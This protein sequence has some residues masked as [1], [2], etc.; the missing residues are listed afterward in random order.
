D[1]RRVAMSDLTGQTRYAYNE[2]GELTGVR[3]GDGSLITYTYDD[4]GNITKLVYPDGSEVAYSY[5]ELDRLTKVTDRDGKVTT[6]AYDKAG[7]MTKIERGDG[8]TSALTYDAAHRVTEIVHRDKKGKLIS[9][10]AYEYDDGNYIDKE[11]ITQDGETLVQT[12]T[13][14]SLGQI[15][16]MTVSS[17]DGKEL[18]QFSYTYDHAGNKLTSTETVDGK[19]SKTEFSYDAENRLL[20]MKSGDKTITYTYDKNG[21]RTS[22]GAGDAKLDYIYDTENRL[23]AVKDKEGLLFAALYDG[24]DNRVFTASRTQA[25]NTYQL[26]KRK[27]ADKKRKSPYTAPDGEANSLFWYGFTQNVVQFFSNFTTSEGYDWIETFDTVS[28]AYHQ[29]VAKDRAT[30]EGLVVNPPS[31]DNLPGEDEVLYRSQV[32]DVLIPYT[33]KEDTYNYYE[34]RNYV[35]DVN[36]QHTQVLQT[37]DDQLQKRETYVYGNGRATYTNES[38]GDSY[39]YLTS[40]S[41]SVTGLTQNGQAVAS[42]SYTLYGATKQTTDTT[43]NPFAYNGEARDITGLD[44]LRARYYDNQ[45]G[46]FLTADSYP[47][48][49]TDPLS[50]NLYAYVQNNPTNYTDPSGHIG[51]PNINLPDSRGSR[52]PKR[53]SQSKSNQSKVY[54][55]FPSG[56]SIIDQQLIIANQS[57]AQGLVDAQKRFIQETKGYSYNPIVDMFRDP[58]GPSRSPIDY[59]STPFATITRSYIDS[60]L[61]TARQ[62]V[63]TPPPSD[64]ERAVQS[65]Q[66]TYDWSRSTTREAKNIH[67]NWTKT[68]EET[69]RHVCNTQTAKGKDSGTRNKPNISVADFRKIEEANKY[70]LT[71][72]EKER[73]DK[74]TLDQYLQSPQ[75]TAEEILYA[76]QVKFASYTEARKDVFPT[77]VAEL[78]GWNNI[79]RLKDGVDPTTGEQANRWFAA[80]EL[81]LDLASNLLPFLKAGKITQLGK[82]LD[83]T[84]DVVDTFDYVSD[85]DKIDGVLDVKRTLTSQEVADNLVKGLDDITESGSIAKNYQSS[86]GYEQA[87]SDFNSLGL[88]NIKDIKTTGGPGKVGSLPDGTKV[89]VRPSSKDGLPTLEFQFKAPYKIRY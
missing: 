53:S 13:Y 31:E 75:M 81:S 7:D 78:S 77:F 42:S 41:G 48:S 44:Y 86:G 89:V 19:E 58:L 22:S 15:V 46:T 38:T 85:V 61:T 47:G 20:E 23:L 5:D 43:G 74:M 72:A 68:L 67:R 8:T 21:N 62:T 10:Y 49:Q 33:T 79:Q 88:E 12:Y 50:Q 73:I 1:G 30:E 76:R 17:K 82:I 51:R 87:L 34:T 59:G 80:G 25:T 2:E 56:T 4:Y 32:Q 37:Y 65:G 6:Y 16:Q 28:T 64:Y 14:D 39:H 52:K 83:A 55:I 60:V 36:Q 84:D 45:A 9:S 29:K 35:N 18:S 69:I 66:S 3:Q 24:D 26:F 71:V 54:P 57:A 40:Q 27:P 63:Y 11:T 70:G